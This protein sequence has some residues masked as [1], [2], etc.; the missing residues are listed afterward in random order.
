VPVNSF[1]GELAIAMPP[2]PETMRL[3]AGKVLF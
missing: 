3:A 1:F 2:A